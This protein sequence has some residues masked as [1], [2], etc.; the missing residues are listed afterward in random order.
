VAQLVLTIIGWLT[1]IFLIGFVLIFGVA[2]W[3]FVDGIMLLAGNQTDSRG[4]KLR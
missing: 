4:L 3:A 1:A 2:V